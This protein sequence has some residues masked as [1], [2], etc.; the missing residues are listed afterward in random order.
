MRCLWWLEIA[1][2]ARSSVYSYALQLWITGYQILYLWVDDTSKWPL[3]G[4]LY[5]SSGVQ[6][7]SVLNNEKA[8]S[9]I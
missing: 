3:V 9:S 8:G 6:I 5:S 7:L 2:S 4:Y 1:K